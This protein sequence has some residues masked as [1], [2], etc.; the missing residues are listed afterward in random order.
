MAY[1]GADAVGCV[2]LIPMRDGVYE[3]SKMAVSPNLRGRGIG[4]RLLHTRLRNST[5]QQN[6]ADI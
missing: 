6:S 1:A 5:A 4:R 2:A 3:I